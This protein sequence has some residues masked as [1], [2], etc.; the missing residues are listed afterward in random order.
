MNLKK[1]K[2]L[3]LGLLTLLMAPLGWILSGIPP[4]SDFLQFDNITSV[5]S[6]IGVEFGFVFGFFMIV[7]TNIGSESTSISAQIA[8]IK[9]LHLTV[10]ELFFLSIC[11][12]FGEEILF[13]LA[14]QEWIHPI[15]AAV[16]FV[17]IHGYINPKDW[18]TT[19]YGIFVLF[20]IIVI[21]YALEPLGIWFCIAAHV[22]YD[23]VLFYYWSKLARD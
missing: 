16:F 10:F 4:I 21:S 2:F 7:L 1:S 8:T 17:A 22:T 14:L 13:R 18:S 15:L 12:G 19:K 9:S 5:W 3:L 6:L 23:F 11:A 20:F